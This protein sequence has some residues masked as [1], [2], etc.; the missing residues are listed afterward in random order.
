MNNKNKIHRVHVDDHTLYILL[1]SSERYSIVRDNGLAPSTTCSI[2][3]EY[4]PKMGDMFR[5][6]TAQQLIEEIICCLNCPEMSGAHKHKAYYYN[7]DSD[8]YRV[9]YISDY[10]YREKKVISSLYDF[11][12][13]EIEEK[14]SFEDEETWINL[15]DFLKDYVKEGFVPY[16]DKE[17][18]YYKRRS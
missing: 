1:L 3:K 14:I 11:S 4:L 18:K 8:T 5:P 17:H 2:I 9:V 15:I 10:E 12:S 16:N 6:H 7:K 13:L